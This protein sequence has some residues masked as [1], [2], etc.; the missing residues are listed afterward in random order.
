MSR[1]LNHVVGGVGVRLGEIGD[2][3]FVDA[4]SLHRGRR[5]VRLR[6]KLGGIHQFSKHGSP[7]FEFMP[8]PQHRVGDLQ[9]ART[10]QAH[11][12]N[13]SAPG[14]RRNRDDGVIQIHAPIVTGK[15]DAPHDA[16]A[17]EWV[18]VIS[19]LSRDMGIE[20]R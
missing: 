6:A 20:I 19:H 3:D 2:Y 8:Q 12:A 1:N 7:G 9:S 11:H 5:L 13:P 4:F 16:N 15:L 18:R 17:S 14:R 10:R